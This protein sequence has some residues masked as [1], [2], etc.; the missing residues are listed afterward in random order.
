VAEYVN[1]YGLVGDG[2]QTVDRRRVYRVMA[3]LA[4]LMV[5]LFNEAECPHRGVWLVGCRG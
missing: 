5:M 2:R 4:G 1:A 3:R